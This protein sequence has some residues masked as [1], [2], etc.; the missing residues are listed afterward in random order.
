MGIYISGITPE[1]TLAARH[2]LEEALHLDPQSAEAWAWLA[3]L[4]GSD[5]LQHWN[6]TGKVQLKQAE[7][8]VQRALDLNPQLALAHYAYGFIHRAKGE[9]A[10][11]LDAFSQALKLNPN[12]AR[13][14]AHK[15][16]ELVN[17]GRPKEAPALVEKAIRLSPR[18]PSLG[19]FYWIYGRAY[20]F[21]GDYRDAVGWLRRSVA[22]R[23]TVWYNRLYLISAQALSGDENE[24]NKDLQSSIDFLAI[25]GSR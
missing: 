17:V 11:A 7:E 10:A 21:T 2:L 22:A 23:P 14:Y 8:A 9:H 20:F 15:A 16:N 4:L 5:Y 18:D 13:A 19:I 1:H 3:D 25:T 12:F 6:N 24:A